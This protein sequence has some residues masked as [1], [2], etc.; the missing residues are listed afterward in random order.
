MIYRRRINSKLFSGLM[1]TSI[2]LWNDTPTKLICSSQIS[3]KFERSNQICD[4]YISINVPLGNCKATEKIQSSKIIGGTNSNFSK[5][6]W[7][8]CFC[9]LI[10][11]IR[12]AFCSTILKLHNNIAHAVGC[13]NDLSINV[14]SV[15]IIS[16]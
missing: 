5:V 16:K 6:K 4:S 8:I 7:I 2:W 9:K 12:R 11:K 15:L 1:K 3:L 14:V 10:H 13:K